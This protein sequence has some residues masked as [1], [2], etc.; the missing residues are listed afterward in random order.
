MAFVYILI[1]YA[2]ANSA[3]KKDLLQISN[4][5]FSKSYLEEGLKNERFEI[6]ICFVSVNTLNSVMVGVISDV[7]GMNSK[8]LYVE[9]M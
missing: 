6:L 4:P 2:V 1:I 9:G 8:E 5:K 3:L 7:F